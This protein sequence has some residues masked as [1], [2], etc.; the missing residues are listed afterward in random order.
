MLFTLFIYEP[1]QFIKLFCKEK[2]NKEPKQNTKSQLNCLHVSKFY[3]SQSGQ[4]QIQTGVLREL[5]QV[6]YLVASHGDGHGSS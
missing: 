2:L 5:E 4:I 1:R 3:T 6:A